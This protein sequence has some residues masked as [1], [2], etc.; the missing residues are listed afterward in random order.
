M[1]TISKPLRNPNYYILKV[2]AAEERSN[3]KVIKT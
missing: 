1:N 2:Y 3:A